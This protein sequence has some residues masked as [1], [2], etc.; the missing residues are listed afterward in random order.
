M[1]YK[2]LGE[3]IALLGIAYSII[4][5]I[6]RNVSEADARGAVNPEP[7]RTGIE[8]RVGAPAAASPAMPPDARLLEAA[9]AA[10]G[11]TPDALARMDVKELRLLV[12]GYTATRAGR[13]R[14]TPADE[15]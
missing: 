12:D 8:R 7:G 1:T 5:W 11:I 2:Y 4:R 9:A 15:R 10:F 14:G 6:G 3:A 13:S